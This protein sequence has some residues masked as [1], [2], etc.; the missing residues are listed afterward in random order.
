MQS[1]QQISIDLGIYQ[2]V[3][4]GF[5]VFII[6]QRSKSLRPLDLQI[7]REILVA[8]SIVISDSPA[9]T[10]EKCAVLLEAGGERAEPPYIFEIFQRCVYVEIF[11]SVG[12]SFTAQFGDIINE[13]P[14]QREGL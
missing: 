2:V 6:R 8:M 7:F 13:D 10:V 11:Q 14:L 9:C 1:L 12:I 3:K 4:H 5:Q